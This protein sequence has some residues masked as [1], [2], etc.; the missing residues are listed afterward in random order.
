MTGITDEILDRHAAQGVIAADRFRRGDGSI[1]E[2]ET[3]SNI[4]ADS[5][6]MSRSDGFTDKGLIG[7]LALGALCA[8]RLRLLEL[9]GG[10][11]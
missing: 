10:S 7:F 6:R 2:A 8:Y 3:I 9:A 5:S 11:N 1:S 4:I